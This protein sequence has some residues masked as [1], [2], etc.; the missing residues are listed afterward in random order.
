MHTHKK[1]RTLLTIGCPREMTMGP[2]VARTL[3]CLSRK[4][5]PPHTHTKKEPH[6]E[7]LLRSHSHP[8]PIF[9]VER[10]TQSA[11][12][13]LP[14]LMYKKKRTTKERMRVVFKEMK[15]MH[16]TDPTDHTMAIVMELRTIPVIALCYAVDNA[17]VLRGGELRA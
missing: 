6:T 8:R 9:S 17:C 11:T 4:P 7:C 13:T 1:E 10:R 15:G 3:H 14:S 5:E 2:Y 16:Y 12:T